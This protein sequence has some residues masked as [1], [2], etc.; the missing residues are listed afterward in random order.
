VQYLESMSPWLD[1]KLLFMSL[2]S[3]LR[4]R[5]DRRDGKAASLHV[6]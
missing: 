4:A 5:W 2:G 1:L 3:T 6:D